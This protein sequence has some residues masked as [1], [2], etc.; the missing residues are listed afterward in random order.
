MQ[1][2]PQFICARWGFF[3]TQKVLMSHICGT[4]SPESG[5]TWYSFI[6]KD[7]VPQKH[8]KV[9]VDTTNRQNFQII[10]FTVW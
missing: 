5:A 8:K 7:P 10:Y 2:G 9:M 4:A 1:K 6:T 3:Y